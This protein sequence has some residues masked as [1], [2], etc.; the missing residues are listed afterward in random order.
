MPFTAAVILQYCHPGR[1]SATLIGYVDGKNT[2][3][4]TVVQTR[5]GYELSDELSLG[6]VEFYTDFGG[7]CSAAKH[8]GGWNVTAEGVVWFAFN[9]RGAGHPFW[10]ISFSQ[11]SGC[12][13][14]TGTHPYQAGVVVTAVLESVTH[15]RVHVPRIWSIGDRVRA[16]QS[17]AGHVGENGE[18]LGFLSVAE[19]EECT[20]E[21]VGENGVE[22]DW[23]YVKHGAN[24]GWIEKTCF[25]GAWQA[26]SG[27]PSLTHLRS[28]AASS[29]RQ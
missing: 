11:G 25:E 19:G 18:D 12:G 9:C 29:T 20:V 2:V 3:V 16:T 22:Q 17:T 5:S 21:Y 23:V 8:H 7:W 6:P 1:R 28:L 13:T 27:E 10:K 4:Q 14:F 15:W 26:V 24:R